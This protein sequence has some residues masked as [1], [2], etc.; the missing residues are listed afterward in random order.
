MEKSSQHAQSIQ[1]YSDDSPPPADDEVDVWLP[2]IAVVPFVCLLIAF[3]IS[4]IYYCVKTEIENKK[5]VGTTN[6]NVEAEE[7]AK[8]VVK[9]ISGD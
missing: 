1:S 9:N 2:E 6:L 4:A 5:K 3:A 8:I 7:D